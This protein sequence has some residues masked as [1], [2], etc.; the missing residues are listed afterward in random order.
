MTVAT[1]ERDT[2]TELAAALSPALLGY[3]ARRVQR[4]DAAPEVLNDTLLIA[5]QKR[6]RMPSD[7][8]RARMWLFVT[9]R[10]CIRNHERSA[11]RRAA[12]ETAL[13]ELAD[14]II[15]NTDAADAEVRALVLSLPPK[16]RELVMLVHWEGFTIIH[17]A[18]LL[19]VSGST[20][21]TR[22]ARARER[23]RSAI[24]EGGD[25]TRS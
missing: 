23:L 2:F 15:E 12:H 1:V 22:Y 6:S 7:P 11:N 17:A 25:H 24:V 20:A 21:R 8:E 3:I 5:W 13:G 4:R 18:E 14:A 10:N 16:Y 9:A 19:R